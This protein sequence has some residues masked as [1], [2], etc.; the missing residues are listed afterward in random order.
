M[1]A[2][3]FGDT[4]EWIFRKTGIQAVIYFLAEKFEFDC[5]CEARR[6]YL[7]EKLNYS[8]MKNWFNALFSRA[9]FWV[10]L[11]A[12]AVFFFAGYF[13]IENVQSEDVKNLWAFL[14]FVAWGLFVWLVNTRK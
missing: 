9:P 1:K 12:G 2:E 7:N 4:L 5:G 6:I 14:I 10:S 13:I 3:G 11:I 8:S